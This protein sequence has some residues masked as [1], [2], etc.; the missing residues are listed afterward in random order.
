MSDGGHWQARCPAR[1]RRV[2]PRPANRRSPLYP[3]RDS[4]SPRSSIPKSQA[5]V[6]ARDPGAHVTVSASSWSRATEWTQTRQPSSCGTQVQRVPTLSWL[7]ATRTR[8]CGNRC[9][10]GRRDRWSKTVRCPCFSATD[11]VRGHP[12]ALVRTSVGRCRRAHGFL[13]HRWRG[14]GRLRQ[15]RAIVRH[16][17]G[18]GRADSVHTRSRVRAPSYRGSCRRPELHENRRAAWLDHRDPARL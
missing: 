16:L 2:R 3:R 1:L 7:A 5:A 4:P 8:G 12:F 15:P 9:W 18:R 10:A 17:F 13:R 14:R 11:I 6:M